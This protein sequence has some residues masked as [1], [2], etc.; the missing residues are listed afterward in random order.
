VAYARELKSIGFDYVCV[1]SGAI[2]PRVP[3][4]FA[5]N[6]QIPFAES[7]K[8]EA[9]I[10]TRGCGV[11]VEPAQAEE[12]VASGKADLVALARAI[13]DDA[14]WG[15]HAAEALG[16]TAIGTLAIPAIGAGAVA[17]PR[18]APRLRRRLLARDPPNQ[19][20]RP[21]CRLSDK[22]ERCIPCQPV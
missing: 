1:V 14:R 10:A 13:L 11:I 19:P 17:R 3:V 9:G 5:P 15:W 16:R 12:I 22:C 2:D 20:A 7:I 21:I 4:P 8:R 18:P 6:Y